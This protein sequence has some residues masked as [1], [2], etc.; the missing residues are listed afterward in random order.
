MDST[1]TEDE[2]ARHLRETLDRVHARG[3]R[4]TID[5]E[6]HPI[7]VLIPAA[8]AVTWR[9]LAK[10]LAAVG[11]PGDGFADDVEA[12]QAAQPCLELPAWPS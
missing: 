4:I 12:A 7:A 6:G 8:A 1:I 9:T 11:F 2:L 3:E 5:R 10:Q